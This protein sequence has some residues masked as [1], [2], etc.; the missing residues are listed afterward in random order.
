MITEKE[1]FECV[2]KKTHY[3]QF[4]LKCRDNGTI[5]QHYFIENDVEGITAF[6]IQAEKSNCDYICFRCILKKKG[7]TNLF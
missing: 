3:T 5:S 4:V 1:I 7:G 6:K 2:N